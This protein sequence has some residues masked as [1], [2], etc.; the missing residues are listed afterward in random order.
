MFSGGPGKLLAG[1]FD[2]PCLAFGDRSHIYSGP[3]QNRDIIVDI[4][5]A[6]FLQAL[7]CGIG[8]CEVIG[9]YLT[10]GINNNGSETT[11]TRLGSGVSDVVF[12]GAGA[13][14][15]ACILGKLGNI[16]VVID[17]IR[18]RDIVAAFIFYSV[19]I[20]ENNGADTFTSR[21]ISV[22]LINILTVQNLVIAF[23]LGGL[24][25]LEHIKINIFVNFNIPVVRVKLGCDN[26]QHENYGYPQYYL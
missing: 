13:Y 4:G 25:I 10:K 3:Y 24:G 12:G 5:L 23:G 11:V 9:Q 26:K 21:G 6:Q 14:D 1:G 17:K 15:G 2:S 20:Q 7:A 18:Y 16:K 8:I 22:V 19:V